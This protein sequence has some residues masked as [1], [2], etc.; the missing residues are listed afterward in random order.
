MTILVSMKSIQ[1]R[2]DKVGQICSKQH[3]FDK[4]QQPTNNIKLDPNELPK[5]M[6]NINASLEN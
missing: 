3:E 5:L 1:K 6:Q 2:I 4:N